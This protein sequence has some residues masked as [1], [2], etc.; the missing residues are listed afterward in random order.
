MPAAATDAQRQQREIGIDV[1]IATIESIVTPTL[2]MLYHV[3]YSDLYEKHKA[4]KFI[5]WYL[6]TV[7]GVGQRLF[8]PG[9]DINAINQCSPRVK[10]QLVTEMLYAYPSQARGC[11]SVDHMPQPWL[12]TLAEWREYCSFIRTHTAGVRAH[13]EDGSVTTLFRTRSLAQ[14]DAMQNDIQSIDSRADL[15][16]LSPNAY[17]YPA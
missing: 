4:G 11:P 15:N 6:Y 17:I 2:C 12:E 5:Q 1:F 13:R 8:Y 10:R 14:L 7:G 9:F 16:A 3:N